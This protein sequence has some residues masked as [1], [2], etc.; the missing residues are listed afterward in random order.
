MQS[1]LPHAG[2]R[3]YMLCVQLPATYCVSIAGT[4]SKLYAQLPM[5][6]TELCTS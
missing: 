1:G 4:V 6:G 5:A 3:D 2:L